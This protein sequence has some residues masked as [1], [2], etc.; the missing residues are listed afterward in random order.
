[1]PMMMAKMMT[2]GQVRLRPPKSFWR[3]FAGFSVDLELSDGLVEFFDLVVLG[4]WFVGFELLG[5]V[6]VVVIFL[7]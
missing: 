6:L 2:F 4:F 3:K 1:M 7:L 5:V